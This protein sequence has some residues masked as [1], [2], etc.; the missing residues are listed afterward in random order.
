M[1]PT[2]IPEKIVM[3]D[4]LYADFF[5]QNPLWETHQGDQ[6][7]DAPI[8]DPSEPPFVFF[9]NQMVPHHLANVHPAAPLLRE[10]AIKG[11]PVDC[12]WNWTLKEMESVIE[13]GPHKGASDS[14]SIEYAQS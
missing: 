1:A 10:Y 4:L 11:C 2:V 8:F 12:G 6:A 7:R 14:I 3:N 13:R 5:A 9:C